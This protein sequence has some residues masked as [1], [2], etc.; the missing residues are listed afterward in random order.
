MLDQKFDK[1]RQMIMDEEQPIPQIVKENI[2]WL[3]GFETEAQ[4]ELKRVHDLWK[5]V[6]AHLEA[7]GTYCKLSEYEPWEEL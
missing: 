1:I 5:E 3:L 7:N 6:R 4:E 2:P